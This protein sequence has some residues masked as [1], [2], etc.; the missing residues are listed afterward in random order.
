MEEYLFSER[1]EIS[2]DEVMGIVSDESDDKAGDSNSHPRSLKGDGHLRLNG[3]CWEVY[4]LCCL[5]QSVT[6]V[7]GM[8]LSEDLFFTR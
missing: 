3:W 8:K 2:Q 1:E 5:S 7:S 4:C 6:V